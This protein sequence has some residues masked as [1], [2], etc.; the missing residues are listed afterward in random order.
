MT[1][2]VACIKYMFSETIFNSLNYRKDCCYLFR[3]LLY[4]SLLRLVI[5]DYPLRIAYLQLLKLIHKYSGT[6]ILPNIKFKFFVL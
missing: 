2:I 4:A 3:I 1:S 6:N 5:S